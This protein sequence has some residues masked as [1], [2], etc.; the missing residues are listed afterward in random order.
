MWVFLAD[1]RALPM[2][3]VAAVF[4]DTNEVAI[5]Q[6]YIE[7]DPNDHTL[8]EHHKAEEAH[9]QNGQRLDEKG[10]TDNLVESV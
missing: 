1:T 6:R 4:G 9:R 3:E 10:N 7:L 8:K 2:E 5:Y